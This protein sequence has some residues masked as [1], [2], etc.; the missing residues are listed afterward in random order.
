MRP[1]NFTNFINFNYT[2]LSNHIEGYI[3]T[4]G[5][6]P[7]LAMNIDTLNILKEQ[8]PHQFKIENNSILNFKDINMYI[9][10]AEWLNYGEVILI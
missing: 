8:L 6:E 10:I 7:F 9:V 2:K 4:I 5:H 1:S 3:A